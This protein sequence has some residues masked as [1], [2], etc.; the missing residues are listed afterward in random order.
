MNGKMKKEF[1]SLCRTDHQHVM[2]GLEGYSSDIVKFNHHILSSSKNINVLLRVLHGRKPPE[3]V[4]VA[5]KLSTVLCSFL[6]DQ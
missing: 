5:V 6:K 1:M 2:K 3:S 4:R